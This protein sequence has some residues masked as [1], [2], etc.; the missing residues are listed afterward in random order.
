VKLK[1]L[2]TLDTS[3]VTVMEA[4]AVIT[5][6]SF[7]AATCRVTVVVASDTLVV[8]MLMVRVT[9]PLALAAGV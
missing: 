5:G 4:G 7:T 6:A 9:S 8:L 2:I 1:P 3:S